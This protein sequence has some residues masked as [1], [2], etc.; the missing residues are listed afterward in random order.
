MGRVACWRAAVGRIRR[1]VRDRLLRCDIGG[2]RV[3]EGGWDTHGFDNTRMYNIVDKYQLPI[4][5]QTLPTLIQDLQER[6]LLD[7]TLIVW[8]G[9][10]GRT[11]EINKNVSRDHWPQC[12][13]TLLAGGG[14]KGGYVYGK[15]DE[16]AKFPLERPVKPEDLAATIYY[17]MGI[18]PA[19]EIYDRNDRPLVIG[20]S[21]LTDV[22]A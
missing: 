16:R 20:G 11:P 6:G 7:E 1:Q 13:T 9:E 3:N 14:V 10:F 2:R 22:I 15:S 4:T 12:Y 21:V 19:T 18:D 8:M 5:D 17:L